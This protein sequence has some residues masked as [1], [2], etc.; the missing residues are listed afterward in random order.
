MYK[1]EQKKPTELI[2]KPIGY[3]LSDYFVF[4]HYLSKKFWLILNQILLPNIP[5]PAYE[6]TS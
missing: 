2:L 6:E 1:N 5:F 4:L 3:T